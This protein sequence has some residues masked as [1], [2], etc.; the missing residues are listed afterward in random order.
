MWS[1]MCRAKS[2][3]FLIGQRGF[4]SVVKNSYQTVPM[5]ACAEQKVQTPTFTQQESNSSQ[6]YGTM[7]PSRIFVGG[8]DFKTSEEDLR[9]YFSKFGSVRDARIIRDRAEVSKGYGFVTY[10]NAD[11]VNNALEESDNLHL[12]GKKLNI[13]R[14]VRKQP[15][16]IPYNTD[17]LMN[18]WMLHPGGYASMTNSTGVT[19]FVAPQ[20]QMPLPGYSMGAG[21]QIIAPLTYIRNPTTSAISYNHQI[22]QQM[23]RF[24]ALPQYYGPQHAAAAQYSQMAHAAAQ[25]AAAAHAHPMYYPAMG[26]PDESDSTYSDSDPYQKFTFGDNP[27]IVPGAPLGAAHLTP[28]DTPQEE[29]YQAA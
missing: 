6:K 12:H 9:E 22:M 2:L 28:P 11:A 15:T 29:Q 18:T 17:P 23:M 21:G 27:A 14:A 13:G 19:Y 3:T 16:G 7:I 26:Q 24:G 10:D 25:M 5:I 4:F 1:E 20:N 8:I